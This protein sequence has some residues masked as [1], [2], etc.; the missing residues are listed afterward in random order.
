MDVLGRLILEEDVQG[1]LQT[2]SI[3]TLARGIYLL[4]VD[5]DT[6]RTVQKVFVK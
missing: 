6:G 3:G 1:Y 4:I 5:T 2:L